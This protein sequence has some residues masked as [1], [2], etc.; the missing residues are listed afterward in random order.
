MAAYR[1]I[2]F[3]GGGIR[4]VYTATL[5]G[6]LAAKF[7]SLLKSVSLY[8]G[9][10]TGGII[11][12]ALAAGFSPEVII[13]WYRKK[14]KD[15]FSDSLF[16]NI[17]DVG[18]WIG[19]DYNPK[20]LKKY[21]TEFFSQKP[22]KT[23]GDLPVKV[24]I[25]SFDLDREDE[26]PRTWKPKFFHN[27]PVDSDKRELIVD[28]AMR[29]SAAP[30]YF[31]S[32]QGYIDGGVVANNPCMSALAQALHPTTGKQKL[33]DI[34]L[35]SIGTGANPRFISGQNLDWGKGQWV[36]PIVDVLMDGTMHVASYYCQQVLGDSQYF[37]LNNYLPKPIDMDAADKI[38]DVIEY[39]NQV[40]LTKAEVWVKKYFLG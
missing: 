9:T 1:I 5:L 28:V 33:N 19:A 37:R 36:E 12:L 20:K 14:A 10:S 3:D 27:Y 11:A 15:I 34:R 24:L 23:L 30:T 31:P 40:D 25:P 39:A 38:G 21:L 4:G 22:M 6:R 2:T 7:P 18:S 26:T 8:S 13:E 16:D 29:T 17:K 32:Y 35:L